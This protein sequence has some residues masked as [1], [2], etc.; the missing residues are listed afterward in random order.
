M[1]SKK[2]TYGFFKYILALLILFLLGNSLVIC[3]ENEYK[4]IRQ[5]EGYKG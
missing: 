5:L 2:K 4:L 3:K 1:D